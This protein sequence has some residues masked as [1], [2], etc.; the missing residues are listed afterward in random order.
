MWNKAKVNSKYD[1]IIEK[2]A[3]H[4]KINGRPEKADI[5]QIDH[6]TYHVI[7]N[8]KSFKVDILSFDKLDKTLRIKVNKHIYQ[9][10]M[11][12]E[13]DLL[14]EEMG[15]AGTTEPGLMELRAP[16]P[17]LIVEIRAQTGQQVRKGDALL[18]LKAMKMENV[19]KSP[20]DGKISSICVEE[21]DKIE[22]D[23]LLLQF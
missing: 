9:V 21:G 1:F 15:I 3:D 20:Q 13:Q 17:G 16:M 4:F 18:V 14:L 8:H 11:Q 5:Q 22:K 23:A 7:H 12:D 6:I 10:E 19:L 2:T